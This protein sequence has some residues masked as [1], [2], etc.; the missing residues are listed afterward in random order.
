LMARAHFP[1]D[2]KFGEKVGNLIFNNIKR[3]IR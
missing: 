1:S 3:K 2:T